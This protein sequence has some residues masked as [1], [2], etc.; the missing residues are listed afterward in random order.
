MAWYE[1]NSNLESHAVAQKQPNAWGLFDMHGNVSEWCSNW[2]GDYS[3]QAVTDP[4]GPIS[5]AL[6]IHRGG[7]WQTIDWFARSAIRNKTDQAEGYASI[8]LRFIILSQ[9]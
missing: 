8:G 9:Q 1:D 6:R 5:G 4:S 3:T 7:S 2:Y